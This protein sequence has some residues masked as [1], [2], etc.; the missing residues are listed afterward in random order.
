MF[1][2]NEHKQRQYK[3]SLYCNLLCTKCFIVTI[4][5]IIIAYV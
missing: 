5:V 3:H 1:A 4:I 2:A